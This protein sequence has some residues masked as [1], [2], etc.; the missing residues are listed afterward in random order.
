MKYFTKNVFAFLFVMTMVGLNSATAQFWSYDFGDEAAFA[1]DW[2]K[3]GTND[4]PEVWTWSNDPAA[5]TALPEPDFASTTV[6]NGFMLFNSDANGEGFPYDAMVTTTS[7]I[8][9]SAANS[10]FLQFETQYAH[11]YG[12]TASVGVSTDGVVFT[13]YT[14]LADV[15]QNAVTAV[16]VV[17]VELPAAANQSAVWIQFRWQGEW[18]YVWKVDDVNLFDTDPTPAVNFALGDFFY[19]PASFAQPILQIDTDTLSFE[20]D[21]I[22]NGGE[23]LTNVVVTGTITDEAGAVLFTD[24]STVAV[25]PVD[26]TVNFTFDNSFSPENLELGVY[27]FNYEV[28][29]DQVDP[30]TADNAA[31]EI[32]LVTENLWSKDNAT[33]SATRPGGGVDYLLANVYT[34]SSNLMPNTRFFENVQF[35]AAVNAVDA[36]LEGKEATVIL[37]KVD[38]TVVD[39]G[40]NG[41][42]DSADLTTNDGLIL[43]AFIPHVFTGANFALQTV[44]ITDFDENPI[45][46]EPGTRYVLGIQ[47][48]GENNVIFQG[49]ANDIDYFQISTIVYSSQWFLGGFGPETA[50]TIRATTMMD[51]NNAEDETLPVSSMSLFP[52]PASD[53]ISLDINLENT[54]LANILIGDMTGKIMNVKEYE[55]LANGTYNFDVSKYPNGVYM[56]R[57]VTADGSRTIKF[58]VQH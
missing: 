47:Y 58:T 30:N 1:T 56:A 45:A 40:W 8:D 7:P 31:S 26:S 23:D 49:I 2:V 32:F 28:T 17:T 25:V 14:V 12:P 22:N 52:N 44:A 24:V 39:A 6:D 37:A 10:V 43:L 3:G 38:D 27:N 50:A 42:D 18:E 53:A 33:A 5:V 15:V 20:A 34:S 55:N 48:A 41:F 54:G 16:S 51:V 19:S 35:N 46:I 21:V 9:C 11:F 13:Y 4:G 36:P 57:L 29:A